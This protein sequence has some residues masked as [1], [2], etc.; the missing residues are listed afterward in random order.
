MKLKQNFIESLK[1]GLLY[2]TLAYDVGLIPVDLIEVY[3]F[4][5]NH[6]SIRLT[7]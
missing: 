3:T 5:L 6:F 4:Y 7:L 1:S 2:K